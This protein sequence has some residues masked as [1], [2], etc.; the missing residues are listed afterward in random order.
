MRQSKKVE[1]TERDISGKREPDTN[2]EA[3]ER[4]KERKISK[5][6]GIREEERVQERA[7]EPENQRRRKTN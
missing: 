7:K 2:T 1:E 3:K 5:Q 6:E 4:E